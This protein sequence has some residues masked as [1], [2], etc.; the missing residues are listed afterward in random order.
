MEDFSLAEADFQQYYQI[1]LDYYYKEKI[2]K[3]TGFYRYSR[4]FSE[5]PAESRCIKQLSPAES[6]S[7]NDEVQSRILRQIESTNALLY[8]SN[9]K[10]GNKAV[11]V[12]EQF[13]PDYV[14]KAKD[15]YQE[16]LEAEK[17]REIDK[18]TKNFWQER[19]GVKMV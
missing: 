4:L 6:W 17:R 8:N 1:N 7:W 9:K 18:Q 5:L 13:Q 3:G 11:K 15:D 10:K 14:K 19:T 2:K 16:Y 12:G